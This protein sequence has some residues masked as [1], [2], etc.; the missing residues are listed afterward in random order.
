MTN[1]EVVSNGHVGHV[2]NSVEVSNGTDQL[3]SSKEHAGHV[4]NLV[5]VSNGQVGLDFVSV[6][7]SCGVRQLR[8]EVFLH[9][10]GVSVSGVRGVG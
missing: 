10:R 8:Q 4:T 3:Y 1:S 2:T 5:V 9:H 6:R 7:G